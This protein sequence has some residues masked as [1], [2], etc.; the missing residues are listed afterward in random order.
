MSYPNKIYYYLSAGNVVWPGMFFINW[1]G[2]ASS[3]RSPPHLSLSESP[4]DFQCL[5]DIFSTYCNELHLK[6]NSK[7]P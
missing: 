4:D 3:A 2:I 5:L 7:K 6:V 1:V